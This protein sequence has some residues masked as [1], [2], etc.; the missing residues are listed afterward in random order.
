[1]S[2]RITLTVTVDVAT[3]PGQDAAAIATQA[4]KRALRGITRRRATAGITN[5]LVTQEAP[6]AVQG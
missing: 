1:M 6:N 3:P 4:L 5:Y 2:D